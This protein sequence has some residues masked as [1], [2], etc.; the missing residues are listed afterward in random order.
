MTPDA[1]L[2]LGVTLASVVSL[3]AARARVLTASGA[4]GA[5]ICGA[6]AAAAGW[7]WCGVLLAFFVS[8]A[9]LSRWRREAKHAVTRDIVEKTDARDLLQV[10][11]NGGVFTVCAIAVLPSSARWCAV[12]ALGAL[13]SATADTWATEIGTASGRS[14]RKIPTLTPVPAGTSGAVTVTGTAALFAGALFLGTVAWIAGFDFGV[15]VAGCVGGVV[16]ALV[17]TLL[18]ATI[19][20]R[21]WCPRCQLPT[22]QRQHRCGTGTARA[23]GWPFMTNDAVNLTSTAC[24]ALAALGADRMLA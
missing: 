9:A 20:D 6:A 24:G 15:A 1:R 11:A 19:Q 12:A 13:A 2:S 14:P 18:G 17:D 22:E 21:R 4:L 5:L 23:G 16:G 8:S 10:I 7:P 3:Y